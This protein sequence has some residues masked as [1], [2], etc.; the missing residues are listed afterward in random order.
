MPILPRSQG[1]SNRLHAVDRPWSLTSASLQ[2]EENAMTMTT[3]KMMTVMMMAMLIT[4]ATIITVLLIT[5]LWYC[6]LRR[7]SGFTPA[8]CNT[9]SRTY[10]RINAIVLIPL[11]SCPSMKMIVLFITG[12]LR[13]S[14]ST[15]KRAEQ[16]TIIKFYSDSLTYTFNVYVRESAYYTKINSIVLIPPEFLELL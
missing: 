11:V 16:F 14:F 8:S 7:F 5:V 12:S 2:A 9:D 4:M 13:W 3:G 6:S 1:T 15:E 10:T